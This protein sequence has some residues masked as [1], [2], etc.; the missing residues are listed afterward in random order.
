[1]PEIAR[2]EPLKVQN[3]I[4]LDKMFF[5]KIMNVVDINQHMMEKICEIILQKHCQA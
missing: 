5:D 2:G 3:I 4:L 1:M